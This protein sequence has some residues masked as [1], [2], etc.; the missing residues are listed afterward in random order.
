[1]ITLTRQLARQTHDVLRRALARRSISR[2]ILLRAD[3]DGLR[4]RAW[5]SDIAVEFHQPGTFEPEQF[6]IPLEALKNCAGSRSEPVTLERSEADQ[7]ILRWNDQGIPQVQSFDVSPSQTEFVK[8]PERFSKVGEGFLPA[9][10]EAIDT[11]DNES[12]RYAC[13]CVRLRGT[14]GRIDATDTRQMLLQSGFKF[15]WKEDLLV[16]ANPVFKSAVFSPDAEVRIGRRDDWVAIRIGL[17]TVY[18]AVDLTGRFPDV[19]GCVPAPGAVKS[20]LRLVESDVRF[21]ERSLSRLPSDSLSNGGVTL[22]LNGAVAVRAKAESSPVAT[23]LILTGSSR[24]GDQLCL[25]TSRRYFERALR[26]GFRE[27]G[28]VSAEAPAVCGDGR[29]QYVWARLAEQGIVRPTE[30]A[31]RIES[32]VESSHSTQSNSRDEHRGN[33]SAVRSKSQPRRESVPHSNESEQPSAESPIEQLRALQHQ[34]RLTLRQSRGLLAALRCELKRSRPV[35]NRTAKP[36]PL[37]A[38][39]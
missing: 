30:D 18:L 11:V 12:I 6:A 25:C 24:A 36:R 38:A 27:I 29:R 8:P 13:N 10:R 9:L 21:L 23:E 15:P 4:I 35:K 20:R 33:H 26:L 16:P 1:M 3:S 17:W 5:S 37:Q 28:F 14:L 19:D 7:V 22:D 32:T 39:G 34:L 2:T 31:I